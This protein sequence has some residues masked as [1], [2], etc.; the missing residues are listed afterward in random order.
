MYVSV[1]VASVAP[2]FCMR[3]QSSKPKPE[4]P[5]GRYHVVAG[6]FTPTDEWASGEGAPGPVQVMVLSTAIGLLST[7][8]TTVEK[9]VANLRSSSGD[10][11]VWLEAGSLT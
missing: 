5:S 1:Q 11:V 4:Q 2:G 9:S 7:H 8:S 10:I 3:S 6:A